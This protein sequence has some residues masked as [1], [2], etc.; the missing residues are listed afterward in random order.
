MSGLPEWHAHLDHA[1]SCANCHAPADK[2]CATGRELWLVLKVRE[3]NELPTLA[4]Q[5]EAIGLVRS[6]SPKWVEVIGHRV[7]AEYRRLR[8]VK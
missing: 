6:M 4:E 8:V 3:I 5:K 1:L 2:Y 7:N